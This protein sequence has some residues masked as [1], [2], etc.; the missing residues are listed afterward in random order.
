MRVFDQLALRTTAHFEGTNHDLS[1]LLLYCCSPS[2]GGHLKSAFNAH[3]SPLKAARVISLRLLVCQS[4]PNWSS[5]AS[6]DM[7]TRAW[8]FAPVESAPLITQSDDRRVADTLNE[9]E[10]GS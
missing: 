2:H 3:N 9:V 8:S 6:E 10:E 5:F 4:D 7:F 1:L